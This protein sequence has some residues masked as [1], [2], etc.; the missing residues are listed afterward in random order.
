M[1]L[2]AGATAKHGFSITNIKT[3]YS[4][5]ASNFLLFFYWV[6]RITS[7]F[8]ALSL[9]SILQRKRKLWNAA[10]RSSR[11]M[12]K[13]RMMTTEATTP[14]TTQMSLQLSWWAWQHDTFTIFLYSILVAQMATICFAVDLLAVLWFPQSYNQLTTNRINPGL[15]HCITIISRQSTCHH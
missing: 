7:V 9:N 15:K 6:N 3:G 5:T 2:R 4:T 11:K 10:I 12:R 1:Y 13:M 14:L 8:S